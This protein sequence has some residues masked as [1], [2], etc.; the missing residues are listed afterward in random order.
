[1]KNQ[2]VKSQK[3]EIKPGKELLRKV[4]KD[5]M[6]KTF[7]R[8]RLLKRERHHFVS[9]FRAWWGISVVTT[10]CGGMREAVTDGVE[11]FVVA[12]RDAGAIAESLERLIEEP[13]LRRR[14]G[15]AA[16]KRIVRDFS[17]KEQAEKLIRL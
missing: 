1:M 10:D 13:R 12:V 17:L 11:A 5:R 2:T 15:E 9:L 4:L 16:R 3:A 7:S 8:M 14:I 6:E